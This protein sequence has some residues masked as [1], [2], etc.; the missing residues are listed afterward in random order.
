MFILKAHNLTGTKD[1]GTS[2]YDVMVHINEQVILFIP[3]LKG[4]VRDE[5]GAAL[6]RRIA[7]AWDK[8]EGK[9]L[10]EAAP[11]GCTVQKGWRCPVHDAP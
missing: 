3:Q 7:D 2:D 6:L 9:G 1:D 5:G 10:S 11:C 4:H 8:L